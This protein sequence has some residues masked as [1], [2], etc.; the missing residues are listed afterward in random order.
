ML[1]DNKAIWLRSASDVSE[2][3]YDKFYKAISKVRSP[4]HQHHARH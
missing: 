2:E 1:N 3:D 4:R